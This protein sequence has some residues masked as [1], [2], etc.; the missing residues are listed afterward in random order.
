[1]SEP[2][3]VAAPPI[4][5]QTAYHFEDEHGNRS[6]RL[7]ITSAE[8]AVETTSI[9]VSD[10][11]VSLGAEGIAVTLPLGVSRRVEVRCTIRAP[12]QDPIVYVSL[13]APLADA[14]LN[15]RQVVT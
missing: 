7:T 1:M 3:M 15:L 4:P 11:T 14:E 12:V 6:G 13:A 9:H 8:T 10:Q 5:G 2:W